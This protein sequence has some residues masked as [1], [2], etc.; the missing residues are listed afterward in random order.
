MVRI[1]IQHSREVFNA[2][3]YV[4]HLLKDAATHVESAHVLRT[5]LQQLVAVRNS[6][7]QETT[8]EQR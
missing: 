8:L 4:T 2:L 1:E 5:Q 3:V 6:L 7:L